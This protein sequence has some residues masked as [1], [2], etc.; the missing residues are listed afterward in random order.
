MP[1]DQ[2]TAKP[3]TNPTTDTGPEPAAPSTA[4]PSTAAP[5]T[6]GARVILGLAV[7]L[8]VF[9][10]H[11]VLIETDVLKF[12]SHPHGLSIRAMFGWLLS[13]AMA[14]PIMRLF[15]VAWHG[16]DR[17]DLSHPKRAAIWAGISLVM[18]LLM[19]GG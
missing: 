18:L 10:V 16:A 14:W 8:F 11:Q 5:S 7:M 1:E 6:A 13:W 2:E 15:V 12:Y 17:P 3:D 4:N 19:Q 9:I